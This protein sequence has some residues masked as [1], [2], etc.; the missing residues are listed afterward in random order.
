MKISE[1]LEQGPTTSSPSSS[2]TVKPSKQGF[3]QAFKST[4]GMNPERSLAAGL[5]AKAFGNLNMPATASQLQQDP[6][7]SD[8]ETETP[9]STAPK[10]ILP[11]TT[12]NDPKLGSIKV[13][14]NAPGQKGIHLDTKHLFGFNVY[15]D[16]NELGNK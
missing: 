11:G 9:Q 14:P 12:I 2:S 16:P 8:Q 6:N 15:M 1:L 13:L 5:A 10:P 7:K 4:I 3:S